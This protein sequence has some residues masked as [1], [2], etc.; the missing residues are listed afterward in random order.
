[1]IFFLHL[2]SYVCA[3]PLPSTNTLVIDFVDGTSKETIASTLQIEVD[4][5]HPNSEDEA[6]AYPKTTVSTEKRQELLQSPLVEAM[7]ESIRYEAY[8]K[9]NDPLFERQWNLQKIGV[10]E[11]WAS[12]GGRGVMVA[13]LDTGVALVPD[14]NP[15]NIKKGVSF[16]TG[17]PTHI[18]QNGHGTH[19]A[20]TI[21]QYTNNKYGAAGIA[22]EATI[23][24]IKVLSKQGFGQSEWIASGIDE[25]VDQGAS[26]INLSLGG[27]HSKIIEI[28]VHKAMRKG[29]IIVAAA[30]NSG[31]EGVSSPASITGVLAVSA[32]N[33]ADELAPYSTF[34]KEVFISAP[35]GDKRTLNGGIIQET[36][37]GENS[38]FLEFQGTSMATPHV[39]GAI[40]VLLGSGTAAQDIPSVLK[41]SA[42]DLG[43][44]GHD[45]KFGYGRLNLTAA[46]STTIPVETIS[47]SV[48]SVASFLVAFGAAFRFRILFTLCATIIM[49]GPFFLPWMGISIPMPLHNPMSIGKNI[50]LISAIWNT[51][52]PVLGLS[53]LTLGSHSLRW[54][55]AMGGI[56]WTVYLLNQ[57]GG[58]NILHGILC[59][60][61]T[62][63]IAA[64]H[65]HESTKQNQ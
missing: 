31:K 14:L 8:A 23:L 29:V 12:G 27:S 58:W 54:T 5:I 65:R 4:W 35:G 13:V 37:S 55:G 22:P 48:A 40:A 46:L 63:L 39:S 49:S 18:D 33:E 16:V 24:P 50:P 20:G 9:P 26:I 42:F 3:A 36:I 57:T 28:A 19:V 10:E 21:A 6:L 52:F 64:I 61:L 1:M 34:G 47:I 60:L 7:E 17:E 25:A 56:C 44:P 53:I 62:T 2:Y 41:E 11:G 32:T 43:S 15:N 59:A 51:I 38:D 30:G 45:K